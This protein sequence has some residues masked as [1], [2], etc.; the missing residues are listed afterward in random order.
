MLRFVATFVTSVH[1][2]RADDEF[3]AD[4]V[5]VVHH[6]TDVGSRPH[7]EVVDG[8]PAVHDVDLD[9]DGTRP[10]RTRR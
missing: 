2:R 7:R 4:R 3:V 6:E 10:E 9:G 5:T 8:E 1:L